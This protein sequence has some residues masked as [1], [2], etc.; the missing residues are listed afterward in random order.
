MTPLLLP[1]RQTAFEAVPLHLLAHEVILINHL[2]PWVYISFPFFA[3]KIFLIGKLI[4]FLC[5]FLGVVHGR[6]EGNNLS[7]LGE[8]EMFKR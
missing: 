3:F 2:H 4:V 6:G 8:G 7:V 5:L 1:Q